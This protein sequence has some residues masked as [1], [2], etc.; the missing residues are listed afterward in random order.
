MT[1]RIAF[2]AAVAAF[3]LTACAERVQS[4]S[5]VIKVDDSY[6]TVTRNTTHQGFSGEVTSFERSVI[7]N[8]AAH[9]CS[10]QACPDVVR[11]AMSQDG[12]V[13]VMDWRAP[14]NAPVVEVNSAV[15]F[16]VDP[17]NQVIKVDDDYFTVTRNAI[18]HG[19]TGGSAAKVERSVMIHGTAHDCSDVTCPEVVREVMRDYDPERVMMWPAPE[20]EY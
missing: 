6:Y 19:I 16:A 5:Q 12:A 1:K 8:G 17:S 3:G 9:D 11:E 15:T 14:E 18:P 4:T 13:H 20:G 2:L 10:D 7:I